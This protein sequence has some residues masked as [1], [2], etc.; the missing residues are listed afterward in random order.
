MYTLDFGINIGSSV[1]K[2]STVVWDIDRRR[3]YVWRR[4]GRQYMGSSVYFLLCF[5]VNLKLL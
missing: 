5:A 3:G 2:C 4:W 1:N